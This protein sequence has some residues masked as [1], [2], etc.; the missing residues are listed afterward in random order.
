[1]PDF[2][3]VK[4]EAETIRRIARDL[5]DGKVAGAALREAADRIERAARR[6]ED[7]TDDA[8]SA[9]RRL[10]RKLDDD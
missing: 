1:M 6:I 2:D 7:L 9:Y 10:K 5:E 4:R 8:E 3:D